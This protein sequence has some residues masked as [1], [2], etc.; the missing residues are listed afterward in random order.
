M[1][2]KYSHLTL[3]SRKAIKDLLVQDMPIKY[4]AEKTGYSYQTIYSEIKN[5]SM[6]DGTYDP[7]YA[8][9]QAETRYN[10]RQHIL[11]KDTEL[12]AFISQKIL[13][14]HMSAADIVSLIRKD[15]SITDNKIC[16]GTIYNAIDAGLIPNVTRE[17][18]NRTTTK[19]FSNGLLR[20]P[21]WIREQT[22]F[23]DGDEFDIDI[24]IK[25]QITFKKL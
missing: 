2:K 6:P 15:D 22:H 18:L 21:D 16:E 24:S 1:G 8:H 23:S 14:D 3:K 25:G 10:K 12:A 4:I 5:N 13:C 9:K 11:K 7:E 19:M 20:L 17:S